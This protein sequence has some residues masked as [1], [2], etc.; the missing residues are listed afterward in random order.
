VGPRAVVGPNS[1]VRSDV[2]PDSAVLGSPQR[3]R[4]EFQRE[5]AA[6]K[7]LPELL[8][9]VRALERGEKGE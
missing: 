3:P 5:M 4:R 6:L 7:K 8:R 2:P 1:G 9:R